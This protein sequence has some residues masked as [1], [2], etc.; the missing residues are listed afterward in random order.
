MNVSPI[1]SKTIELLLAGT[2]RIVSQGGQYSGKTVN[3]LG[4]LAELCATE[5]PDGITPVT[6]TVTAQSFPHIKGGALRD[7]ED[8]VYPSFKNQIKS[9]HKTDHLFTFNSGMKMEFRVFESEMAA[10]GHKR[11]RLF[12]NEANSFPYMIF[13][14]LDSRS[15]QTILDYNP[16]IRFWA[17]EK[18]IGY[19]ENATIYS[20]HRHNPFLSDAKHQEIENHCVFDYVKDEY[21]NI[22]LDC[23]GNKI[24]KLND[25]GQPRILRGD[26]ELWK[27]YARGLTGNVSGVIF[28]DWEMIDDDDFPGDKDLDWVY[29][30]DFGYTVDPTV[31]IKQAKVGDT[32]FV[33]ELAYETGLPAINQVQILRANGFDPDISP[34]YCEHDWDM[35]RQLRQHG[36]LYAVQAN[37]GQGSIKA[38]IDLLKQVKVKYPCSSKNIHRERSLYV[39]EKDKDTGKELNI[40]IDAN[41]HTFDAIRYGYYTRYLKT[42]A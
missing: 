40:P 2:R 20:D 13:F 26:Y 8:Y 6:T 1:Y 37:K 33:K 4:A 38:G 39:W 18:L 9:Y 34:L 23:K 30:T 11:K 25:K 3:H 24:I 10:R 36:A 5:K 7:F 32:L 31:L 42:G 35:I 12:I 28:P 21:G 22:K 19:P 27:V 14:Q 17:H 41:N 16:S 15:E 29:S